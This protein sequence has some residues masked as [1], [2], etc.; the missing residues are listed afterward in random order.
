MIRIPHIDVVPA[1]SVEE[2]QRNLTSAVNQVID[3]LN[4]RPKNGLDANGYRIVN[5]DDPSVGRDAVNLRTLEDRLS[6][7]P[8]LIRR[9]GNANPLSSGGGGGGSG[10]TVSSVDYVLS[11]NTTI[12]SPGFPA[13]HDILVVYVTQGAGPYT[14]SFSADFMPVSSNLPSEA[15]LITIFPFMARADGLWWPLGLPVVV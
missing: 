2:L 7:L 3:Q 5:V 14:I 4:Q 1:K 10:V 12:T 8:G 13:E 6:G 9:V 11:S 15:G